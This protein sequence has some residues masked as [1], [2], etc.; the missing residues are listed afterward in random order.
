MPH[1]FCTLW[2]KAEDMKDDRQR[3]RKNLKRIN[4]EPKENDHGTETSWRR[5]ERT[6]KNRLEVLLQVS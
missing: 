2:W 6:E 1:C 3:N 4:Q 5:R